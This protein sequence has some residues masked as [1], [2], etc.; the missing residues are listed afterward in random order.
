[1]PGRRL[2]AACGSVLRLEHGVG[3]ARAAAQW[4]RREPLSG[5]AAGRSVALDRGA[6]PVARV[7]HER[8]PGQPA[9][10]GERDGHDVRP[11]LAVRERDLDQ[12]HAHGRTDE[13]T[14]QSGEDSPRPETLDLAAAGH[15][16]TAAL[17]PRAPLGL[18]AP[19]QRADDPAGQPLGHEH[20]AIFAA[21]PVG[22]R[23]AVV[24]GR[25]LPLL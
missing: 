14:E 25:P 21:P 17:E 4:P 20:P 19:L 23:A 3:P 16:L 1:M 5:P 2:L 24:A 12:E 8:R 15:K 7:P 11:A 10:H 9:E 22:A 13:R 6:A 18:R